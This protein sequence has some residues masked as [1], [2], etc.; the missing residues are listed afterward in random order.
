MEAVV[1]VIDL[2]K[3]ICNKQKGKRIE[4]GAQRAPVSRENNGSRSRWH[5]L[6]H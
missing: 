4:G 3:G 6:L 1:E 2:V 5:Q